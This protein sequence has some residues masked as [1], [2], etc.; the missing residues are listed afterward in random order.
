MKR[1]APHYPTN[2]DENPTPTAQNLNLNPMNLISDPVRCPFCVKSDFGVVYNLPA[3]L[4]Q[5][6]RQDIAP[7]E[8]ATSPLHSS[9]DLPLDKREEMYPPG[10]ERVVLSDNIRPD[11]Y[12]ALAHRRRVEARRLATATALQQALAVAGQRRRGSSVRTSA[13]YGGGGVGTQVGTSGEQRRL[14]RR[15][16]GIVRITRDEADEMMLQEAIR[17]SLQTQEEERIKREE[18]E[19]KKNVSSRGTTETSSNPATPASSAPSPVPRL[20]TSPSSPI[21][22]PVLPRLQPSTS[23]SPPSPRSFFSAFRARSG[24]GS[25][26]SGSSP[27]TN[28]L[29]QT[30]S[31]RPSSTN[32]LYPPINAVRRQPSLPDTL[33]SSNASASLATAMQDSIIPSGLDDSRPSI[34]SPLASQ[35]VRVPGVDIPAAEEGSTPPHTSVGTASTI[36]DEILPVEAVPLRSRESGLKTRGEAGNVDE[37]EMVELH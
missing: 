29:A 5:E 28:S 3:W 20:S 33:L 32:N 22:A 19:R 7:R 17:Q 37:R 12:Q 13:S 23:T 1:A 11:W 36:D 9:T 27:P 31:R 34:S 15:V 18:E 6:R 26:R 24:S 35:A 4:P 16:D 8:I 25:S 21:T 14:G 30:T 2:D 10:H